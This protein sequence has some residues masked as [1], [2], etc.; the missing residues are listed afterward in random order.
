MTFFL[1][2]KKPWRIKLRYRSHMQKLVQIS[3]IAKNIIL[4]H[5]LDSYG[6]GY[7]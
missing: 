7:I 1:W 6:F 4:H 3:P 2:H 5:N